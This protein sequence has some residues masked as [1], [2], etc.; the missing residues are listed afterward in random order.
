MTSPLRTPAKINVEIIW[1]L[2]AT[3][4]RF[5]NHASPD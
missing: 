5:P 2:R 4:P 1:Q 3:R